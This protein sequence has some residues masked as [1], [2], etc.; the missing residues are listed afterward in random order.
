[1]GRPNNRMKLTGSRR[2]AGAAPAAYPRCYPDPGEASMDELLGGAQGH[3]LAWYGVACYRAVV[4]EQEFIIM[5]L[6]AARI[7]NP[8]ITAEELALL[9]DVLSKRTLGQLFGRVKQDTTLTEDL[10][11]LF[12]KAI[13]ARNHLVHEFWYKHC[14]PGLD[15]EKCAVLVDELKSTTQLFMEAW[16]QARQVADAL[17]RAADVSLADADAEVRALWDAALSRN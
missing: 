3:M 10:L 11:A 16:L 2:L 17:C 13:G 4:F 6:A 1:M 15:E 12:S 8:G 9:D 14:R 5:T 7:R